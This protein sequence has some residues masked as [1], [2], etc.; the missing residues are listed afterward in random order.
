MSG[1]CFSCRENAI[2]IPQPRQQVLRTAHWRVAH[3]FDTD[4]PGWLVLL[5]L[6]HVTALAE[7]QPGEAAELG[8]LLRAL[9]V[10][11][12]EVLGSVKSYVML[13]AEAEGFAHLHFHVVPRMA[14]QPE[15]ERGPRILARLGRPP[16]ER[17]SDEDMDRLCSALSAAVAPDL[18]AKA[19]G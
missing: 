7:L 9:S 13:F 8:P 18:P 11:L 1:D 3:A 17:M 16:G 4:L 14:D 6:R 10:A 19:G 2:A 5:P 12:R 15:Q